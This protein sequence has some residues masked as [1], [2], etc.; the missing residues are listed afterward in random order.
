VFCVVTCVTDFVLPSGFLPVKTCVVINAIAPSVTQIVVT[1]G[2]KV[3]TTVGEACC[4][5]NGNPITAAQMPVT[6][7]HIVVN[8]SLILERFICFSL[9]CYDLFSESLKILFSSD[10]TPN[11]ANVFNAIAMR[12]STPTIIKIAISVSMLSKKYL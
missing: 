12:Q 7:A 9:I 11:V 6:Q 3:K 1:M 8:V 4:I 2:G 5:A 10:K